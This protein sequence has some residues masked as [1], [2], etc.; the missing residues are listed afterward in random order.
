MRVLHQYLINH[1]IKV[2]WSILILGFFVQ[3]LIVYASQ[4]GKIS[5]S[6]SVTCAMLYAWHRTFFIFY[7]SMPLLVFLATTW[8]IE[9][10]YANGEWMFFE[11]LWSRC[12]ITL[13]MIFSVAVAV[14]PWLIAVEWIAPQGEKKALQIKLS[15]TQSQPSGDVFWIARQNYFLK[16][17][18]NPLKPLCYDMECYEL[19]SHRLRAIEKNQACREGKKWVF[20]PH[21]SRCHALLPHPRAADVMARTAHMHHFVSLL[22]AYRSGEHA[23]YAFE[24]FKRVFHFPMILMMAGFSLRLARVLPFDRGSKRKLGVRVLWGMITGCLVY[25]TQTWVFL[26]ARNDEISMAALWASIPL[27]MMM[28]WTRMITRLIRVGLNG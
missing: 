27:G 8:G 26:W 18:Q 1:W 5:A 11:S 10:L 7:A 25:I 14:V 22:K 3:W 2:C 24:F 9:R 12:R 19:H 6:Y 21:M 15:R 16:A 23:V 28:I 20:H 4:V 13:W 17:H